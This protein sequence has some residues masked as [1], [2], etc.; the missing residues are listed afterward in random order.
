MKYVELIRDSDE[1][2]AGVLTGEVIP[3]VNSQSSTYFAEVVS[4]P[5]EIVVR[6]QVYDSVTKTIEDTKASLKAKGLNYLL[7]TDW[8][9]ARF[10]ETGKAIPDDILEKREQARKDAA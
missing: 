1:I 4:Y 7:S 2:V 9:V 6:G 5:D 3:E 8:Y 10:I